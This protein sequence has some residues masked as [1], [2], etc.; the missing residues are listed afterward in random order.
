MQSDTYAWL[1]V[2]VAVA[3]CLTA[4][5]ALLK[6]AMLPKMGLWTACVS[7]IA[8]TS[9]AGAIASIAI[10]KFRNRSHLQYRLLFESN[11]IPMWCFDRT[12]LRFLAVNR[13]AIAR[14]G[15]TEE[16][17]LSMTIADIRPVECVPELIDDVAKRYRGL[18]KGGVWKHRKKTG[19]IIHVEIVCHDLRDSRCR[20]P[21]DGGRGRRRNRRAIILPSRS[22]LRRNPRVLFQQATAGLGNGATSAIGT[23]AGVPV[24]RLS[25]PSARYASGGS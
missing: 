9:L 22:R 18:Q 3:G 8:C 20:A 19:E 12:S 7:T 23:P 6:M 10:L 15:Y 2:A 21:P 5:F 13:A 16:E 4:F 11:P 14:Y 1:L 25:A 17:F 24:S